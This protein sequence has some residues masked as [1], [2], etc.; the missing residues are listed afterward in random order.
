MANENMKVSDS[1]FV[2]L[3]SDNERFLE[4]Y[5]ALS[6][7]HLKLEE[8]KIEDYV[9]KDTIYRSL[10]NDVCKL[11]NGNLVVLVEHQST[12]NKN[13]PL[14]CLLYVARIYE[15]LV[16]VRERYYRGLRKIPKPEFYVPLIQIRSGKGFAIVL[17]RW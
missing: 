6:G 11:V 1:L 5:N 17:T 14:R 9:I 16:P 12:V 3:F 10:K 2:E 13:M 7:R 4:L 15:M 8:T